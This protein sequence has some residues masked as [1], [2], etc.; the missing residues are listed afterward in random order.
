VG[1]I[2]KNIPSPG[3]A[4]EFSTPRHEV[5]TQIPNK[6]DGIKLLLLVGPELSTVVLGALGI[7]P[8]SKPLLFECLMFA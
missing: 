8:F 1:K 2:V 5:W 4:A 7:Y 6:A 3:G